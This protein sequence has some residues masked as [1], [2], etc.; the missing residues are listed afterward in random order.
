MFRVLED[1]KEPT[2]G[3]EAWPMTLKWHLNKIIEIE[4]RLMITSGWVDEYMKEVD[5]AINE[6]HEGFLQSWNCSVSWLYQ[7]QYLGAEVALQFCKMIPLGKLGNG[8]MR[9]LCI[10]SYYCIWIHNYLKKFRN[11]HA[12][13]EKNNKV[14]FKS[15][16]GSYLE[17]V[18]C[19]ETDLICE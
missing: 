9:S 12:R 15:C 11:Q 7:C 14:I 17:V 1:E 16:P 18:F 5:E 10:F 19:G 4:N 8:Y 13:K 6:H 3:A 2:K